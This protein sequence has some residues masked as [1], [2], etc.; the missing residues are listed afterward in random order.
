MKINLIRWLS[1][2]D[3]AVKLRFSKNVLT[4]FSHAINYIE[5]VQIS[6]T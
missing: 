4:D 6:K 1:K 3:N 2:S 5:L